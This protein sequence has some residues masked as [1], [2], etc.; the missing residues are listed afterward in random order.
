MRAMI[1]GTNARDK[2]DRSTHAQSPT[3]FRR[4][5]FANDA[6]STAAFWPREREEPSGGSERSR[7]KRE[8]NGAAGED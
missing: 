3:R 2:A 5:D 7:L 1:K 6:T 8:E 4:L